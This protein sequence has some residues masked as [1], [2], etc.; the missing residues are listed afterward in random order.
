MMLDDGGAAFHPV[1]GVHIPEAREIGDAGVVDMAAHDAIGADPPRLLGKRLLEGADIVDGV[2][3]PELQP[4]RQRPVAE[5]EPAADAIEAG[6]EGDDGVVGAGAEMRQPARVADDQIEDVAMND[7]EPAAV[8]GFVDDAVDHLDAA[9]MHSDVVAQELVVI[10]RN[11]DDARSLAALA[12]QFLDDVVVLLRPVP[13]APQPP[14]VDDVA[15][16]VDRLGV[17]TAQ[18]IEEQPRLTALATEVDVGEEEG[19]EM[20]WLCPIKHRRGTPCD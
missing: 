16:E 10:A 4:G 19:A 13:A 14:A 20:P 2:L 17:V 3:D 1:A 6:V 8:G 9:E 15:D 5:A 7:Q 11:I 18:E 12:Q